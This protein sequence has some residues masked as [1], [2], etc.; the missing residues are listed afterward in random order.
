MNL[1][2]VVMGQKWANIQKTLA[3]FV[4]MEK[5][6]V[7]FQKHNFL[8]HFIRKVK[9]FTQQQKKTKRYKTTIAVCAYL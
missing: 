8:C 7:G 2:S 4:D 5:G 9:T 3:L 1:L 6:R